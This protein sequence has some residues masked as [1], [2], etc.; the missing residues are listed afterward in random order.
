MKLLA[1]L[2][3]VGWSFVEFTVSVALLIVLGV[4]LVACAWIAAA[5]AHFAWGQL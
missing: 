3:A 1:S 4:S 2:A 5:A